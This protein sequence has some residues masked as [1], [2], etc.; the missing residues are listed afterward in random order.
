MVYN[1]YHRVLSTAFQ[2]AIRAL[3][4]AGSEVDFDLEMMLTKK[5]IGNFPAQNL[6]SEFLKG[7]EL[8][9]ENEAELADHLLQPVEYSYTV[10]TLEEP[11]ESCGLE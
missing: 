5:L 2:Q 11:A 9:N 7:S 4:G 10:E 8:S 6:M 1:Y 3:S